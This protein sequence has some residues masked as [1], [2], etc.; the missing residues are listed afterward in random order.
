MGSPRISGDVWFY[1]YSGRDGEFEVMG[2]VAIV[3]TAGKVSAIH[4][5]HTTSN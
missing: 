2:S 5:N 1:E 3:V 4:E